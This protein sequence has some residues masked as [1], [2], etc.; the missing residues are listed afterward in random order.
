NSTLAMRRERSIA[1]FF[2]KHGFLTKGMKLA[3]MV[4]DTPGT[5][6]GVEKGLKP[7]LA[8]V[9]IKPAVEIVYPDWVQ[10]PWANY[11]LQMQAAG[12]THVLFSATNGVWIPPLF[13]MQAA[14]NQHYRPKWGWGTDQDPVG[15]A[16]LGA[17]ADQLANV[18]GMGWS[19]AQDT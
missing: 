15:V 12:V 11:V 10:S 13:M 5:R 14:E 19:P 4:Q 17:P 3:I 2:L 16:G 8:A 7:A 18:T 6:E 1:A 9:G